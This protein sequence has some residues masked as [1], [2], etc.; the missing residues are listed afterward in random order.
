MSTI[1]SRVQ[2]LLQLLVE[3]DMAWLAVEVTNV[4]REGHAKSEIDESVENARANTSK[5]IENNTPRDFENSAPSAKFS[6]NEQLDIA[7]TQVAER[8]DMSIMSLHH[9]LENLE[10]IV[11]DETTAQ[12]V[13]EYFDGDIRKRIGTQNILKV[14]ETHAELKLYLKEWHQE[15]LMSRG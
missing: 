10:S 1:D 4:I 3:V 12:V 13:I 8:I 6:Q 15:L 5:R 9:S 7:F 14:K 2:Q 11:N